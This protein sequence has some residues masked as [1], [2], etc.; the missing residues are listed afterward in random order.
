MK[1]GLTRTEARENV[2]LLLFQE[3][4]NKMADM[5]SV[6]DLSK[7]NLDINTNNYVRRVY[8]GIVEHMDELDGYIED[9]SKNW[10]KNRISRV[11][12]S[13][14]RL[15][16]YE[17]LYEENMTPGIAISQAVGIARKYGDED[18]SAFV[19]GV[20]GGICRSNPDKFA[21]KAVTS[22][23]SSAKGNE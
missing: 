2:F 1:K 4:Y 17:M 21:P 13:C 23:T 15:A 14:M 18:T 8:T 5:D 10:N 3:S 12:V 7:E 22:D 9:S 11:A 6:F 20:L 19:N 16:L